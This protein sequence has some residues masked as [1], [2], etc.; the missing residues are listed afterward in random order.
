[1]R[2]NLNGAKDAM[3]TLRYHQNRRTVE[4]T[5]KLLNDPP[6]PG[7]CFPVQPVLGPLLESLYP[8]NVELFRSYLSELATEWFRC[9]KKIMP[10][11]SLVQLSLTD[12]PSGQML[13]LVPDRVRRK[14]GEPYAPV[15][16]SDPA[17][18]SWLWKVYWDFFSRFKPAT[19]FDTYGV[20][21]FGFK[22]PLTIETLET[23]MVLPPFLGPEDGN[24]RVWLEALLWFVLLL[25]SR[26]AQLLDGC[27]FCKRYFVRLRGLKSGQVY[28]RGG[29]SCPKCKGKY[30]KAGTE[31]SRNYAKDRMLEVAA[32][33]WARWKRT[34][35]TPDKYSAVA[36]RINDECKKEIFMTNGKHRIK[37]LWV[38]RNKRGIV[39]R[40][41]R[42]ALTEG[43]N[44]DGKR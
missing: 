9:G 38:K 1:M 18:G 16:E 14:R 17:F 44:Q 32:R 4:I 36:D 13:E 31:T 42:I 6:A 43:A 34:H 3:Q 20:V 29:P 10:P 21:S 41:E 19:W 39:E 8:S 23:P 28:K 35:S 37:A 2:Y 27:A 22:T 7:K 26:H 25:D 33:E 24:N 15:D 12:S 40:A 11:E 5:A 30:S